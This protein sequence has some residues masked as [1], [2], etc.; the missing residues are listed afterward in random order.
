[1]R[2][3]GT[4]RR[5]SRQDRKLSGRRGWGGKIKQKESVSTG[6]QQK[7]TKGGTEKK[8]V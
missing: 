8:W 6:G 1:M 3:T 7:F 2:Q 4:K 5:I